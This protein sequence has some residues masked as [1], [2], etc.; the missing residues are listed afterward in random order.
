MSLYPIPNPEQLYKL[1]FDYAVTGKALADN[2]GKLIEVNESLC[3]ITG[4][5]K[6]ELQQ[7]SIN[8]LTH[9]SDVVLDAARLEALEEGTHPYYQVEKRL[10]HKEGFI[11]WVLL[12]IMWAKD[13]WLDAPYLVI[14]VQS[15]HERNRLAEASPRSRQAFQSLF[16]QNPDPVFSVDK[17]GNFTSANEA[18]VQLAECSRDQLLQRNFA[19]FC[20]PQDLERIEKKFADAQKGVSFHFEMGM[21]TAKGNWRYLKVTNLPVIVD[22]AIEGVYCIAKDITLHQLELQEK[23]LAHRIDKFFHGDDSL[24]ACL[25]AT[26]RELC[27]HTHSPV[28]EAWITDPDWKELRLCAEY[29]LDK[30]YKGNRTKIKMRNGVGLPGVAREKKQTVFVDLQASQAEWPRSDF[31]KAN[32]L[33]SGVAL[34]LLFKDEVICVLIFYAFT[35]EIKR[36]L[37]QFSEQLLTQLANDI[38]RRRTEEELNRFFTLTSDM[39]CVGGTDGSL[40]K[41]NEAFSKILGYSEK[42]IR[43]RSFIDLVHPHDRWFTNHKMDLLAKASQTVHLENRC[44]TKSG[45]MVWV[46]WIFTSLISEDVVYGIGR[47][48]S[49]AKRLEKAIRSEKQRFMDM[50]EEAPVTMCILKGPDHIFEN[51]NDLYYKLTGRKNIIGKPLR[52]VFPELEGQGIF[53]LLNRVYDSGDI[54]SDKERLVQMVVNDN[55]KLE[56]FYLS[57]MYQPYRNA[58]GEVE[59]VF[60]FGVDVTEQVRAR[61]KVEESKKQYVDLIQNLPVAVYTCDAEGYVH[62][63]N[64]A[65]VSL[66]G[67][68][69]K[70]GHDR[71]CGSWQVLD[72]GGGLVPHA[73]SPMAISWQQARG[74]PGEEIKI[75]RPDGTVSHV[76][77]FPSP[78]LDA[79]GHLAGGVNVLVNITER[80]KAEE[81]LKKLSLIARK[82]INT[83][84]ITGPDG[85]IEWVNDAFTR[86]TGYRFEEAVGRCPETLLHGEK[87]DP[88]TVQFMADKIRKR[89]PFKCELLKYTKSGQPF[90]VE[91]ESQPLFDARGGLAYYFDIETD[92][93]ER[94]KAYEKLVRTENEVRNFAGQL[95]TMLEEERSRI[96][97]EIHDEFGQQLTGL[98]MS[99]SSLKNLPDTNERTRRLITEMTAGVETTIRSL[100]NFSTE[101][102]P[103][104]LDTLGLVPSIEW[105]AKEFEN[106]TGI[107]CHVKTRVQQCFFATNLS[108]TFFRVCQEALTNVSKHSGATKVMIELTHNRKVLLLTVEDNG[109][110]IQT[111]KLEDPFSMGLIGMR[112]RAN[113][114]GGQLAIINKNN[115]GTSVHLSVKTDG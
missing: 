17:K 28:G 78:V 18:C 102:R 69:P 7:L 23:K 103:G 15:I 107:Q 57:Y 100:R 104:I 108:I 32:K 105:L 84:I 12:S 81:A 47:D 79:D 34:P 62:L 83:V 50:F 4:Y 70:V 59:G 61:K 60:Y 88:A 45:Q 22:G 68:E 55:G 46:E 72:D 49:E 1:A 82:T 112:E 110:G 74:L 2:T 35:P 71:W 11:T 41:I 13:A 99:L 66:W 43:A 111:E 87:T 96:A 101:L 94:K 33:Q 8:D 67:R 20:T 30:E 16:D 40:K 91:I 51:A 54:Y 95:N 73:S 25:Q 36:N 21:I 38:Q 64:K 90:W 113:L 44:L 52:A 29:A 65:A 3:R 75:K 48:S 19:S 24:E 37:F 115:E 14:Q 80:K 58:D 76:V 6:E 9:P 98:K 106:K 97:R 63:Y 77:S 42:E 53:E 89:E 27:Y 85:R 5:S 93:S 56:D 114:I 31:F 10:I 109:R 92:I 86:I 26:L 39:L